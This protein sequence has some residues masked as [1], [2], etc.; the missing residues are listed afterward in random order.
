[1]HT[2]YRYSRLSNYT[3]VISGVW[4]LGACMG[5]SLPAIRCNYGPCTLTAT[6]TRP[7]GHSPSWALALTP[8]IRSPSALTHDSPSA[9]LLT[10]IATH[11]LAR[12]HGCSPSHTLTL[13]LALTRTGPH[14][15]SPSHALALMRTRPH[16]CSPSHRLQPHTATLRPLSSL[17]AF[18]VAQGGATAY[19][20]ATELWRL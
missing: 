20:P 15:H 5:V 7:P 1:M 11:T 12:P 3:R 2:V 19:S 18:G 4:D 6:R 9:S 8:Q 16:V 17:G 10:H 13:T 14:T